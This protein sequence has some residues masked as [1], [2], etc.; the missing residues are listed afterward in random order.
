[1][2]KHFLRYRQMKTLA[3][4]FMGLAILVGL[5]LAITPFVADKFFPIPENTVRQAKPE[6]AAKALQQWFQSSDEFFTD[7]QA[8]NKSAA[9]SKTSWFAFSVNRRPIEKFILN[10]K[11]VQSDLTEAILNTTFFKNNRPAS[12]WQPEAIAQQT[13]FTGEDQGR[14]VSLI[15]NPDSKRGVLVTSTIASPAIRNP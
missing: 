6:I 3:T 1:M 14:Q 15:Y 4:I 7:V 10:K 13:Y 12:W 8:I 9:S 5:I 2:R 11:L